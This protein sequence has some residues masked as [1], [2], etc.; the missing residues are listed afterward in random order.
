M[1][2]LNLFKEKL[3]REFG[4]TLNK[5]RRKSARPLDTKRPLHLVLKSTSPFL[6]LRRRGEIEKEIHRMSQRFGLKVYRIAVQADH[7]HLSIR[8][9]SR[10][11]YCRWIRGLTSSLVRRTPGLKF[12]LRPYS[13]IVSWGREFHTLCSYIFANFQEGDFILTCHF[14]VESWLSAELN[15]YSSLAK[16]I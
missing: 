13:R 11:L 3:T 4:G 15:I 12:A 9:P 7:V 16:G 5:G 8:I 2:Q 6:L 10:I 1:K 14:R